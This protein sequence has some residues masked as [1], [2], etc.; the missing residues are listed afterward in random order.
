MGPIELITNLS[1][2]KLHNPLSGSKMV[3]HSSPFVQVAVAILIDSFIEAGTVML[4][5][6]EFALVVPTARLPFFPY[7]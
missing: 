7:T 2:T 3:Q 1:I 6:E 5:E 4:T